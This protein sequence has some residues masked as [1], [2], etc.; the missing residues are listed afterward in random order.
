MKGER[1]GGAEK[2]MFLNRQ[3]D[4]CFAVVFIYMQKNICDDVRTFNLHG[5]RLFF[6]IGN[7]RTLTVF[8]L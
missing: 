1:T 3:I 7:I 6:V 5:G 4:L 8:L 2:N